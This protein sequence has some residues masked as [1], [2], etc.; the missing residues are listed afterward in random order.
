MIV[1]MAPLASSDCIGPLKGHRKF[2]RC[3]QNFKK[4]SKTIKLLSV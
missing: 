1:H 2:S 4:T 3:M